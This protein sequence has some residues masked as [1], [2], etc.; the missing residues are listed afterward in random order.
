MV[1]PLRIWRHALRIWLAA[2]TALYIAFWLQ[3]GGAASAAVFAPGVFGLEGR[4]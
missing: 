3:L 1:I 2:G 4:V